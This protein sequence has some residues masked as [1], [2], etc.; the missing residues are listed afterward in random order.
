MISSL[1]ISFVLILFSIPADAR[2]RFDLPAQ[3]LALALTVVGNLANLNVLFDSA[4]VD[5]I[6]APPL[7]AELSADDALARLL[8]GTRLHAIHVNEKTVSIVTE[9]ETNDLQ[10]LSTSPM[11]VAMIRKRPVA[12]IQLRVRKNP[13]RTTR[14]VTNIKPVS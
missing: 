4:L 6:E 5:G 10:R 1:V 11:P 7:K 8:A 2:I 9:A 3:P 13:V 14:I 12:T